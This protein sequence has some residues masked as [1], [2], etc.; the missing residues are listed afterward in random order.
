[1]DIKLLSTQDY[2]LNTGYTALLP[3]QH[4][5]ERVSQVCNSD[6]VEPQPL[7]LPG[8]AVGQH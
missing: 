7:Q 4:T 6:I 3:G 2:R 5:R 8:E 1:M